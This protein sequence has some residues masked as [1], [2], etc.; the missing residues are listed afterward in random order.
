MLLLAYAEQLHFHS[1]TNLGNYSEE[2]LEVLFSWRTRPDDRDEKL[3]HEV[4]ALE[5]RSVD[6]FG[7]QHPN[8]HKE[9]RELKYPGFD[10]K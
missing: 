4:S 2:V 8:N 3:V 7:V 6:V 5:P 1:S 10:K 9:I